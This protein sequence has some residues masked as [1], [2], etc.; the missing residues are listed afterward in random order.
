[1]TTAPWFWSDQHEVTLQMAGYLTGHDE[2][3]VRGEADA[4]STYCYRA[5]RLVAVESV[6]RP[7]DHVA[8]APFWHLSGRP[9]RCAWS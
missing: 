9:S 7:A 5:G 8:P 1:V 4:F 2:T 3:V 6:N